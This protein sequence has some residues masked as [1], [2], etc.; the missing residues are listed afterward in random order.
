MGASNPVHVYFFPLG[1]FA[2]DLMWGCGG[3]TPSS[4]TNFQLPGSQVCV[5][6][7]FLAIG[8]GTTEPY[9]KPFVDVIGNR[10][11]LLL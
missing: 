10:K 4:T 8:L 5:C 7:T 2:D 9:A 6:A 1:V 3:Y 11:Q